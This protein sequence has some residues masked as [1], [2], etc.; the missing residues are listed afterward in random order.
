MQQACKL[1]VGKKDFTSFRASLCQAK[2]PIITLDVCEMNMIENRIIFV[3]EA[4]SFLHHMVRNIM[5][6]IYEIGT[7]KKQLCEIEEIFVAKDRSMAGITAPA[8]GLYLTKILYQN[9]P[10]I[11]HWI[12][13]NL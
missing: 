5:G 9:Y 11:N 8:C 2:S 3:L 4:R 13:S 1:F 7:I 6:T 12:E 10:E